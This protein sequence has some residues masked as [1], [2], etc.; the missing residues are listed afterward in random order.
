MDMK[1]LFLTN[2]YP[3]YTYGG[4]GVHVEYLSRELLKFLSVDVRCFGDQVVN[5]GNLT[6]KGYGVDTGRMLCPDHLKSV[7]GA[8]NRGLFF[9]AEG[10]VKYRLLYKPTSFV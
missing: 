4:A 6:V 3:P 2:E 9:N 8:V 5:E 1:V 10:T 7:F